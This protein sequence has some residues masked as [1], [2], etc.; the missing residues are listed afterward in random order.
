MN[1]QTPT[2]AG[3]YIGYNPEDVLS[4]I[5]KT[6]AG[7]A[8]KRYVILHGPPGTGK[9]TLVNVIA[10]DQD[11]TLR[12]SNASDSRRLKDINENDYLTSGIVDNKIMI[13]LDECEAMMKTTWKRIDELATK[14]YKIPIILITNTLSK[15]PDKIRKK[16]IEKEVTVNRF[17]LKAFT[18]RVN[19]SEKLQLSET[20]INGI[21]DECTSFRSVI[22]LLKWGYNDTHEVLQTEKE[23]I[24]SAMHG[25]YVEFKKGDLRNIITM[26]HDNVKSPAM[27]SEADIWLSRY[28]HGYKYGHFIVNACLNAIRSKK[29]KLD[30]PRTYALIH[31]AKNKKDGTKQK[32]Q[33][34]NV[35]DIRVTGFKS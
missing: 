19:V 25:K 14:N 32:K 22:N 16:S 17:S 27:I 34:K 29:G 24:L 31:S 4:Y 35:P 9:T 6:Y 12:Y 15:I 23:Q 7:S 26:F 30:Y 5:R 10:N 21:V 2:T 13:C 20:Q 8:H 11:L 1:I 3:D 33:K 28:E 18:K